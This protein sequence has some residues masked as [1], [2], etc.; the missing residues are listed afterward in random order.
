MTNRLPKSFQAKDLSIA[1]C[2]FFLPAACLQAQPDFFNFSY[3][4]PDSLTVDIGCSSMLQGNVPNPV[5]TPK[6]GG[7][8]ITMSMFDPV[9][10]GFPYDFMFTSGTV[11][12]IFWFVKDDLGHSHTFEYYINFVDD[13]PPTFDLTGVFDTLEFSSIV[14]VPTQTALPVT[15]NCTAVVS[16]TF[17]QTVTP[18]TCQSGTFTR[19]WEAT[20]ANGN[21]ATYTQTIIIYQDTLPPQITGYPQ[22]GSAACEQLATAYPAWRALQIA[23]FAATDA[24]GVKS[25]ITNAPTTFPPGCK[26]PLTV[27]FWAIDNCMIQQIVTVV[28]TT[29]DTED[30]VVIK[31]PK[32]TVA[33]CSQ[34]DNELAKLREWISTKAY[35]QVFDSCSYPL[36]Y[37]MK[38]GTNT[39]DSAQV[40][41]A[42]LASFANGCSAQKVHGL[43]SVNFFV[44]DDCG[45]SALMGNAEFAA[46]DTLR[47][48]I[49][50]TNTT[51]QCGGANDQTA[52][53]TWINAHGN[54]T[55]TED[56]SNFTWTD[57]TFSTS[58]GLSGAGTFN[59]GPYPAVLA[60]NC[61]W[62]TDVTF[63]ATDDCG[64]SNTITLRWSIVDTQAPTFAGLAP[65]ITVHCP[66]SLPTVPAATVSDNCDATPAITFARIYKDSI[67]DGSY[68]VRT[69]WT[70]TDDCGNADSVMQDIFVRDT[71]RPVFTLIPANK[72]FRCDTF[73]L[74]PVPVMGM[75]IL[76][77]DICSPIVSITTAT[78]SFQNPDPAVCGHYSYNI[79]RTFTATDE[80]QNTR[81]A[82]Q[83]I[84][85]IDNLGPVPGGIL[86]TT[87]LCNA[88]LPFPAPPPIATDACSGPTAA[89]TASGQTNTLGNCTD[90]YTIMVHWSAK[91]VC[92][93][94]TTF[95][96]VLHVI[97]T[98]PP[99]LVNIPPNV[100]VECDAI[101][102]AP[103]ASTFNPSD[104]CD[105]S[106]AVNLVQTEIRNPDPD[107]C[108]HWTNYIVKREWTA[109]D[110]CGNS[111]TYTQLIQ[112]EDTTP[113]AIVPP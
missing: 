29:S 55:V 80:C 38:I 2:L 53:R 17:Y 51:E 32:D 69:T 88:L 83:T 92:N 87:V 30:P 103:P 18:D 57:F 26:E 86:D 72:T 59:A 113:P 61:T 90:R 73:V 111:R 15:D 84:S 31:P 63:R 4:G 79:V 101:P 105:L 11:A 24:S 65:S 1:F 64:N 19:T 112:I 10:S 104:N 58:N 54:A 89:P 52:L 68:T 102:L 106:V 25:L 62:F 44:E 108:E 37:S 7:A 91:D 100:T 43:V 5:V 76:A 49:T 8:I 85:V 110:N 67:C 6:F 47:P 40:V 42:F 33:Y 50:G 66:N 109:T 27:K 16:D 70:A 94:L 81:T 98:V 28:F 107:T 21:T 48:T 23:N 41:A 56:C 34:S 22:S 74:P 9:A 93:N 82:T 60:N 96:Q 35:S 78:S 95:N 39:V 20:D 12:H 75:N 36:T 99:A 45:N 97:D 14:Q 3:N 71:T 77:T 13:A 46:I